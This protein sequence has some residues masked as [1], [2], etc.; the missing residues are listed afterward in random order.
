MEE[1]IQGYMES[2]MVQGDIESN[3]IIIFFKFS[4]NITKS[5]IS[6]TLSPT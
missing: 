5:R 6:D 1:K 2:K 4:A 3:I